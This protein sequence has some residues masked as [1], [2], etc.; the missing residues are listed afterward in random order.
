MMKLVTSFAWLSQQLCFLLWSLTH[1]TEYSTGSCQ[2]AQTL[3]QKEIYCHWLSLSPIVQVWF[4][5]RLAARLIPQTE[6]LLKALRTFTCNMIL[7]HIVLNLHHN[8]IPCRLYLWNNRTATVIPSS[9]AIWWTF[10]SSAG[11]IIKQLSTMFRHKC[12]QDQNKGMIT[13]FK[14]S[15]FGVFIFLVFQKLFPAKCWLVGWV[16]WD[17]GPAIKKALVTDRGNALASALELPDLE[18]HDW[19]PARGPPAPAWVPTYQETSE[20]HKKWFHAMQI[21]WCRRI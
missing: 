1:L 10:R 16:A 3:Q 2:L 14:F 13:K 4:M 12:L 19:C 11:L 9:G 7:H 18:M 15:R 17:R 8:L 21:E 5:V 6:L 20:R